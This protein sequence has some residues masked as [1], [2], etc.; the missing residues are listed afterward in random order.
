[1]RHGQGSVENVG[2]LG[3]GKGQ[4]Q[5]QHD[6]EV[7]E[8][9]RAG[10]DRRHRDEAQNLGEDAGAD[11]REYD[12]QEEAVEGGGD[13]NQLVASAAAVEPQQQTAHDQGDGRDVPQPFD[14]WVM[15]I[16]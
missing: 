8:V 9:D 6:R 13:P 5:G 15:G 11:H 3:V 10:E 1:M 4:E 14:Q 2:E 7:D 16:G 12:P